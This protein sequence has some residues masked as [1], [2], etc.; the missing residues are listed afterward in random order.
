M[1][2]VGTVGFARATE[3]HRFHPSSSSHGAWERRKLDDGQ[4]TR[5]G[6]DAPGFRRRAPMTTEIAPDA[7]GPS[8]ESAPPRPRSSERA[9]RPAG[10]FAPLAERLELGTAT[11][12]VVGLGYVGLP[13]LVTAAQGGFPVIGYDADPGKVAAL[14]DGISYIE[15]VPTSSIQAIDQA[16]YSTDP[17]ALA[18]ADVV[19]IAVPTPLHE[20]GPDLSIVETAA[21]DVARS[22]QRGQLVV[23]ESTT[24]PGTTE[25]LVLPVLQESGLEL[26]RDFALGYSPERINP[27][28]EWGLHNTPKIVAGVDPVSLELAMLTYEKLAASV[29]ATRSPREAEMAKL[30]ENT[31]RSVNIALVNELATLAAD[32]GVDIWSA[33][34][35]A[36]TKPFGYLPFWPGAGVGGHC[37]AVDPTYLSWQA[38][39]L[40]GYGL[41]FVEHSLAVNNEMPRYV[42]RRVGEALNR[43]RQSLAGSRVLVLGLSYKAGIGDTR[44]SPAVVVAEH[45]I[46]AGVEFSYHDPYVPEIT[47]LG[48]SYESVA[49]DPASLRSADCVVLLTAHPTFELDTVVR[50]CRLLFDATGSTRHTSDPMSHVVRL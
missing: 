20:G 29:V 34:D 44:E 19:I 21:R 45:L 5:R 31:F 14:D 4:S 9:P 36:A 27:G 50:Q 15:D 39:K 7:T 13:L 23:L 32:M 12:A 43:S 1:P 10:A 25:E 41:G 17:R 26:G 37:I 40:R 38:T 48:T 16:R 30:I 24:Y 35:A 3:R 46:R 33:L 18:A 11:I 47:I 6:F 22:L 49:F 28:S 8:L 42:S 2:V